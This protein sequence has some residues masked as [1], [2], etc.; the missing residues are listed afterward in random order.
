[1]KHLLFIVAVVM[2]VFLLASLFIVGSNKQCQAQAPAAS[3]GRAPVLVELFTS[4]GCSD[5]PPADKL[6]QS[7]D[8]TQPVAGAQIIVLS[9]HVDYWN[10]LGWTDPYSSA[11]FTQRQSTYADRFGLG[12]VYTPQMV[13]DGASEFVG[14]DGS[15][16]EKAIAKA[17]GG[18]KIELKASSLSRDGKIEVHVEGDGISHKPADVYL[19]LA[20]NSATSQ[21]ARGEN[22]GRTLTH[23]AVA[24]EFRQ[25]GTLEPGK[26]FIKDVQVELKSAQLRDPGNLR[27]VVFA[28]ERGAGSVLGSAL[29]ATAKA[30][31]QSQ[32]AAMG[33]HK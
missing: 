10:R 30:G 4:E 31:A 15:R 13:V 25:I 23:V 17:A 18:K 16:A 33:G 5:C 7:L 8:R 21:V 2:P 32:G 3:A 27:V 12:S 20:Q 19:V 9:E 11:F 22:S 6:L 1:V 24:R 14:S 29:A 28:Q 26:S